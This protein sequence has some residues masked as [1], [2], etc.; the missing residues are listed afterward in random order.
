MTP[1]KLLVTIGGIGFI[2]LI[3]WFFFGK[4]DEIFVTEDIVEV[5]VEGGYKPSV[6]KIKK[7]KT[8]KL[9]FERLDPNSCLE[10][11]IIP[12]FKIKKYLP[13]NKRVEIALS[14]E[15]AG[16]YQT[17]CGMGMFHGKIIVE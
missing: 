12:E 7:G 9:I 13:L 14:P 8:T 10:E 1:E 11:I 3:Y 15:K 17:H 16:T 4:K 5:L 2:G 6:I